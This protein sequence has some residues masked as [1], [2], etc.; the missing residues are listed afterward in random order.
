M[1]EQLHILII[2]DQALDAEL[3]EHELRSAGLEFVSRRVCTRAALSG[4]LNERIPDVVL[5]DFSM[6]TDLDGFAALELTRLIAA[7]VP[8]IFVSGTIGEERAVAALKAGATD[9]VLKDRLERLPPVVRRALDEA[10]AKRAA[11]AAQEGLRESEARFRSF[12]EYLPG[13]ASICDAQGR[14]TYVN[15]VWEKTFG[16]QAADAIGRHC[17]ELPAQYAAE[18]MSAYREVLRTNAP[19]VHVTRSG[20]GGDGEGRWWLSHHFPIPS[21][22]ATTPLVG[23]IAVDVT[24][25]TRQEEKIARLSRI[26][27]VLGGIN[28]AIVR[29][30]DTRELLAE[31]CG[32]AKEHGGFGIAWIGSVDAETDE[33][34][35]LASAG[36]EPGEDMAESGLVI[37][38]KPLPGGVVHAMLETRQPAMC[39]DIMADLDGSHA[40]RREAARRG[41]RSLIALPLIVGGRITAAFCLYSKEANAFNAEEV[42]LLMQLASDVAFALE[43][44]ENER[45]LTYLA[46]HDPV[47]GL[48]NRARLHEQLQYALDAA[49]PEGSPVA[50]IVWDIKRFRVINNTFGRAAGDELLRIMAARLATAWPR[51]EHMARLSG[52]CFGGFATKIGRAAV[53]G[54]WLEEARSALAE[55][56]MLNGTELLI[57]VTAGIAL[58]PADGRDADTLLTNAEAALKQA[59]VR[60]D[61]YAFYEAAMNAKVAEK[62]T[63]ESRLRRALDRDEFVLH[64]QPKIDLAKGEI[65]GLEALIRWNDPENGLIPPGQFI[66]LLE[67]TGLILDVG[68]WAIRRALDDWRHRTRQGLP[69]PRV[70]VNVSAIQLRRPEFVEVVRDALGGGSL[71]HGLDLEITESLLMEEI[72]ANIWKLRALKQLGINLA[73][74]DFGTGYSSLAYLAQLPVDALKIDRSFVSTMIDRTESMTII[75]SIISL[76]HALRMRV[77]AEGVETDEQ[78]RL[79]RQLQ[80]DEVQGYAFGRPVPWDECFARPR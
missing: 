24:D 45:R 1:S 32:I 65:E 79:L 22:D 46:Q 3:C 72:E 39:N 36:L 47:T 25:R 38:G 78:A 35:P 40:R 31:A 57:A 26:H 68:M 12:M 20:G 50:V 18:L 73:I 51:V 61:P 56:I 29:L 9:Y 44:I 43:Y 2:E 11:R 30:R 70:A 63:L 23:T 15:E 27:A 17:D 53:I 4:A 41:F 77:I 66:G 6:P 14:Y 76:A 7:D 5:S 34:I 58:Y 42:R 80:C 28:S 62:L 59:K 49:E 19:V 75:S 16:V 64:Y 71:P 21:R 13:N 37:V 67:E 55:P 10:C 60:A 69:T 8:F 52:D 74:D 48:A 54:Q 33:I